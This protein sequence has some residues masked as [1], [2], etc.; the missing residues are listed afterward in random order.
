M[1]FHGE[2]KNRPFAKR[3]VLSVRAVF[4]WMSG[5]SAAKKREHAA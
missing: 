1:P 4:A 3:I 5:K 2:R